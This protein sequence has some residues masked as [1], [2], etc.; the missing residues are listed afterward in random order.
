MPKG[1]DLQREIKVS[2]RPITLLAAL[3][4]KLDRTLSARHLEELQSGLEAA[5]KVASYSSRKDIETA[6][7]QPKVELVYF[8]CHGG[9][10]PL[11]GSDA[12]IP[13]LGIG[14]EERL[15]TGDLITWSF[16]WESGHWADTSPLVF[17][18]GCHTAEITPEALVNFVD[19]FVG[20]YAAGVIGTEIVLE[21]RVANEAGKTF[22]Y[23]FKN[24]NCSVGQALQQVRLTLL[25]KGN[26]L[27]L[28]YTPYCSADLHLA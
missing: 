15:T 3:S 22:F 17:I 13:F 21:Q 9:R 26:L 1:R 23:Y 4:L 19:A 6:L 11:P 14:D 28:V 5:V 24:R 8:Y 12:P 27:G 16:D 2:N 10:Q 18:N 20:V 25:L 7:A